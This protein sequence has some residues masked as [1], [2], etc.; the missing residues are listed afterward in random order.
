MA[1]RFCPQTTADAVQHFLTHVPVA[2]TD[3][4]EQLPEASDDHW[5]F[6]TSNGYEWLIGTDGSVAMIDEVQIPAP[7]KTRIARRPITAQVC[8]QDGNDV[9]K[10]DDG[11][12][13]RD[14]ERCSS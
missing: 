10:L 8:P 3:G 5:R 4:Y 2:R 11:V 6:K 12:Y 9:A 13:E 1:K 7:A 14:V